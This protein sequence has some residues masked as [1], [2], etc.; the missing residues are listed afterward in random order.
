MKAD[1]VR[2]VRT[3]RFAAGLFLAILSAA[4]QS[5]AGEPPAAGDL[6][7]LCR[8]AKAAFRPLSNADLQKAKTALLEAA[9]RLDRRLSAAGENGADWRKYLQW[10]EMQ[11]ELAGEKPDFQVLSK[12]YDKYRRGEEGLGLIW[13]SDVRGALED[14]LQTA[15]DLDNPNLKT[16]YDD[17]LERLARSLEA[18][19]VK[20]SA[21]DAL[22]VGRVLRWL[23]ATGQAAELVEAVQ[24]R[25]VQPNLFIEVSADVISTGIGGPVDDTR[26]ISDR[27]LG[28]DICAT[29]HTVG[30]TSAELA[31]NPYHGVVDTVF[32][33][34]TESDNVGLHG[35]V[36]IFSCASTRFG[37]CK[38]L[39]VNA[40]G[41]H[42]AP[43]VSNAVNETTI[44]DIRSLRGRRLVE[45]LAWR[46]ADKQ[47]GTAQAI[48]ASHA[49][50]RI[51]EQMDREAGEMLGHANQE[52]LAKFRKPLLERK[53][54]PQ[55]LGFSTTQQALLVTALDADPSQLGAPAGP[56]ELAGQRDMAVRI[57]ESMVN[58][59]AASAL[60]GMTLR[61]ATFQ[62][63]VVDL[64][65][66]LPER[67]KPDDDREPWAITFARQKPIFVT[68]HDN[69]L[70]IT[71]RGDRYFKG[72]ESYPGMDVTATYKIAQTPAGFKVVREGKLQIFPARF[73]DPKKSRKL[74]A[75]EITIRTLLERRFSKMFEEEL[76]G[77]GF[78]LPGKWGKVGKM[79]P[80]QMASDGG[81]LTV[82]WRRGPSEQSVAD[83]R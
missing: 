31:P 1:S 2:I 67:L 17:S 77:Q 78:L 18:Y 69:G 71:L 29:A 58:N 14:Y 20:P 57:H 74:D 59:F 37:A 64:L 21:E 30:Q 28:T 26:Q 61:E 65:G 3:R 68:F 54:F 43:A 13:F 73:R 19:A 49:E 32:L 75:K 7:A 62:K 55:Q 66:E 51:N 50:C 36:E 60:G 35:P 53:L 39:W 83:N 10:D 48:A 11:N 38:R 25:L 72:E 56:P 5:P 16:D 27:I 76:V 42:S 4:W 34:S 22:A 41:L 82:A 9:A 15:A 70:T 44:T 45:R 12:V 23:L 8:A 79:L 33:G 24:H 40:E 52:F 47:L 46:R 6:P 81:W 80:V 63:G